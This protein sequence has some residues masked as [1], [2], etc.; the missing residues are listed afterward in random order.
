MI[1]ALLVKLFY[2]FEIFVSAALPARPRK[3][4]LL[5]LLV[6]FGS[7]THLVASDSSRV[8]NGKL[9]LLMS[10][11]FSCHVVTTL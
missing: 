1:C 3:S 7:V 5:H 2:Q 6:P 8:D 11:Y 9:W 4:E 10:G